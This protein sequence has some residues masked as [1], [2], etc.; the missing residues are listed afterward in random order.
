MVYCFTVF[1]KCIMRAAT[2][3]ASLDTACS[4]RGN[5]HMSHFAISKSMSRAYDRA[6]FRSVVAHWCTCPFLKMHKVGS[7]S[8]QWCMK[9]LVEWALVA[10]DGTCSVYQDAKVHGLM[11]ISF[12]QIYDYSCTFR[13]RPLQIS[14]A[15][16]SFRMAASSGWTFV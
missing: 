7:A 16:H 6:R 4:K 8:D 3:F 9:I 5:H 2:W 14:W 12:N 1:V 10:C 13:S 15:K 11:S